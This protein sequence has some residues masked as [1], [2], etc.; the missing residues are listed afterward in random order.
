M[1]SA[2][3]LENLHTVWWDDVGAFRMQWCGAEG[4]TTGVTPVT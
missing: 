3:V 1:V 2:Q 4:V